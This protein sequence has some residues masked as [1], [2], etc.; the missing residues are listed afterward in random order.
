MALRK[1]CQ[2]QIKY[3]EIKEDDYLQRYILQSGQLCTQVRL[4][5]HSAEDDGKGMLHLSTNYPPLNTDHLFIVKWLRH[6]SNYNPR[7]NTNES[8]LE[9]E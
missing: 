8:S 6:H 7:N 4:L 3:F 2:T 9:V 5:I 1:L